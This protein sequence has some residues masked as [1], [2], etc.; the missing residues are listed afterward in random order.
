MSR[1]H[2]T[3]TIMNMSGDLFF[4]V[5]G[6]HGQFDWMGLHEFIKGNQDND[7]PYGT[8]KIALEN[9]DKIVSLEFEL[10]Y[11]EPEYQYNDADSPP[12]VLPGYYMPQNIVVTGK[13][14]I[15]I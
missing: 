3:A 1:D 12:F 13:E 8:R 6:V 4:N 9:V 7:G 11:V 15:P 5:T 2:L 14:D 10:Q